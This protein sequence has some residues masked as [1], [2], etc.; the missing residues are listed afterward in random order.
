MRLAGVTLIA[1]LIGGC[2]DRFRL[3]FRHH[4]S[5]ATVRAADMIVRPGLPR[6]GREDLERTAVDAELDH[7]CDLL[8]VARLN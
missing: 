5:C 4:R 6:V 7:M 2:S 1:L 3:R 8:R